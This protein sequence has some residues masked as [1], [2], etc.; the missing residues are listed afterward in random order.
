M[1]YTQKQW[2]EKVLKDIAFEK[3]YLVQCINDRDGWHTD[4]EVQEY[5]QKLA[6]SLDELF[7]I[8]RC[9]ELTE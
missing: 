7:L 5:C 6:R 4:M 8:E 3:D 9:E 1:V 2:K